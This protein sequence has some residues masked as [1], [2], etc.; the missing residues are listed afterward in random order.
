MFNKFLWQ[1]VDRNK[2]EERWVVPGGMDGID[3][4]RSDLYKRLKSPTKITFGSIP[5]RNNIPPPAGF[6]WQWEKGWTRLY[7]DDT[8]FVDV[9][10]HKDKVFEVRFAEKKDGVW[11]RRVAFRDINNRP[12]GYDGLKGKTCASCHEQSG[13][14]GYAV[15]LV[16]GG[17]GVI[18]DPIPVVEEA[19]F[20]AAKK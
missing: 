11:D 13:L 16:P 1:P 6:G 2:Q 7:D 9:L 4:W 18:S 15:G 20:K 14:G 17:D 8:L 10:S 3:G 5:V 19:G 12:P